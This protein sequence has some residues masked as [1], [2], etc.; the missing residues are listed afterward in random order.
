MKREMAKQNAVG[1]KQ[2]A[3]IPVQIE[4]KARRIEVIMKKRIA[5]CHAEGAIQ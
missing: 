3:Q 2:G 5:L 1:G 4:T